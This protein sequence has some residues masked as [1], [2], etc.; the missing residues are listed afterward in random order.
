M[1]RK[2]FRN[3]AI[4]YNWCLPL[5]ANES[6]TFKNSLQQKNCIITFRMDQ[7]FSLNSF[8]VAQGV[9]VVINNTPTRRFESSL[10]VRICTSLKGFGL[11]SI[12]VQCF[13]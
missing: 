5:G 4:R 3:T 10:D 11:R 2:T 7:T 8:T 6:L 1:T 12:E 13:M 9:A